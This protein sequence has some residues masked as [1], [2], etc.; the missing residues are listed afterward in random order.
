MIHPLRK[1]HRRMTL[2]IA[3]I[4]PVLFVAG[5]LSRQTVPA[6]EN[7]AA[8]QSNLSHEFSN[9]LFSDKTLWGELDI[10]T[11]VLST[12][13]D[14][15]RLALELTPHTPL[16]IADVLVYWHSGNNGDGKTL[17]GGAFLLGTLSGL[18]QRL[19]PLP[20]PAVQSDGVVMLYSLAHRKVITSVDLKTNSL[21][22]GGLQ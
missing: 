20:E 13:Q 1:R 10:R 6:T 14:S 21:L 12:G 7:A 5:L 16:K 2:A 4:V 18:H 9:E 19:F 17:P 8:F 11:R 15:V 22:A 3:I